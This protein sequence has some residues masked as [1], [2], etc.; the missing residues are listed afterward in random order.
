MSCKIILKKHG[1]DDDSDDLGEFQFLNL[2]QPRDELMINHE[3][4]NQRLV[5]LYIFHEPIPVRKNG[6]PRDFGFPTIKV[7]AKKIEH[8]RVS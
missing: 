8:S 5:V 3:G 2:P 6:A 7:V 4:E 1:G